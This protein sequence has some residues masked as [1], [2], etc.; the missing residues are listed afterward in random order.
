MSLL[1]IV[2]VIVDSAKEYLGSDVHLG[3]ERSDAV[4]FERFLGTPLAQRADK[5]VLLDDIFDFWR[6][7]DVDLLIPD[8]LLELLVYSI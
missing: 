3:Y 1:K 6:R 7:S 2:Q 8:L 5:L 4:A